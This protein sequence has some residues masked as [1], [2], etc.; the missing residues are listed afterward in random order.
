MI[1]P[2]DGYIV[3]QAAADRVVAPVAED[4]GPDE[5]DRILASNPDTSLFLLTEQPAARATARN[6]LDRVTSDGTFQPTGGW[7]VY[8]IT[9]GDHRQTGVVAE[10]SVEA[11]ESNRIMRHENTVAEVAN[12][13]ADALDEM[14]GSVHP[15]SL[16]YRR[17]AAVDRIV[18]GVVDEPPAVRVQRGDRGQEAWPVADPGELAAALE[19]VPTL[20]IADG[21]HRSAAAAVL[22]ERYQ[23]GPETARSHFLAALFPDTDMRVLSYHRCLHLRA[24]SPA[25][26][27]A[28]IARHFP[29]AAIE[30]P[31]DGHGVPDPGEVW[32]CVE[33]SWYTLNL[34]HNPDEGPTAALDAARLQHQILGPICDV[35]DPRTDPRLN[36]VP[37]SIP[38]PEM[39]T[40]CGAQAGISFV[41]RPPTVDDVIAVSDAGGVM[42]PK[43]TWFSPKIGAGIFLRRLDG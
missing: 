14:G 31:S 28:A 34:P 22:A 30:E 23:A 29:I 37:G 1:R 15:V 24:Y 39:A 25:E 13:V 38:L 19:S 9:D 2:L 10:V 11:Y 4:L 42:P 18:A 20:Y 7:W 6:Y 40:A 32:L 12:H 5:R 43:S 8:R 33:G 3:S 16:V 21:H 26:I 27:L 35:A 41:T 36:Y 17:Q